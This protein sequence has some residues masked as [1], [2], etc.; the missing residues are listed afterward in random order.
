M[1]A[2]LQLHALHELLH[3]SLITPLCATT[4]GTS[5]AT[6]G[7]YIFHA[8]IAPTRMMTF[9]NSRD[10]LPS[11]ACPSHEGQEQHSRMLSI[12]RCHTH[13][14]RSPILRVYKEQ[15]QLL[16][17][18]SSS[19]ITQGRRSLPT[20]PAPS[21]LLLNLVICLLYMY[22]PGGSIIQGGAIVCPPTNTYI[23]LELWIPQI[24]KVASSPAVQDNSGN[25]DQSFW[26]SKKLVLNSRIEKELGC[27]VLQSRIFC[28]LHSSFVL[29]SSP[30]CQFVVI[31]G[32]YRNFEYTP[33][34][35]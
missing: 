18:L 32:S 11:Y 20:H 19:C 6:H 17:W 26:M 21:L 9:I 35:P 2:R 7:A 12:P 24:R 10:S 22:K 25:Q 31:W 13:P 30:F 23:S 14:G 34:Q 15:H 8:Y 16:P 1:T 27:I 3:T 33:K 4:H 5:V 29:Y 28:T